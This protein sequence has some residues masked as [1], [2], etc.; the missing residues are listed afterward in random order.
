ME[1]EGVVMLRYEG[2]VRYPTAPAV[3]EA[4]NDLLER[5]ERPRTFVFDLSRAEMVDSTHLGLMARMAAPITVWS[6]LR[7]VIVTAHED[8]REV[9]ISMSLDEVCDVLPHFPSPGG[10]QAVGDETPSQGRL[11]HTMLEAHKALA[12]LSEENEHRFR[13]VVTWLEAERAS[14]QPS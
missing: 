2:Q 13:D 11:L 6:G 9:L 12:A 3:E 7:P 14:R 5:E 1:S 10:G 8:L 4:V